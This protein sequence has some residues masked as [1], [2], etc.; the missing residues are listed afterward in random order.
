MNNILIVNN[1]TELDFHLEGVEVVAAK[2]YLYDSKYADMHNAR[3]FNLCRSYKYQST[4]YYVSLLAEARG[5]RVFPDVATIQDFG[6]QS[7]IRIISSDIDELIQHSLKKLKSKDFTLSIYFG[8]NVAKQYEKLS[9]EL[10]NLFQAPLVRARFIFNKKWILQH[11]A[12]IPL[13]EIPDHHKP[14]LVDFAKEYFARKTFSKKRNVKYRYDLAILVNPEED[15]PPSD[16]K[17]LQ[18]FIEAAKSCDIYTEFI[19]RD[20]FSR[21][22]EFDALFIR[23]TTSVNHHTYRF[24]RRAHQED[25]VVIDDPFSI[26]KCTNKVYLAELLTRAKIATPK[27]LIAHKD[28]IE[29]IE[30]EL[31]YPCVLKRP[32]SSF[33]QGVVKVDDR[34]SLDQALEKLLRTSDL[35]IAQEYTPTEFDWRIGIID[36]TPLYACKYYMASGHWQIYN[37]QKNKS[38]EFDG[39][40]QTLPI[41]QV[42]DII[43]ETA[44]KAANLIGDGLYGV[45]LKEIDS[46]AVVIEVNDN[47]SI[48]AGIE[49]AVLH[50]KL[51]NSIMQSFLNRLQKRFP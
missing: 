46:R 9:K 39:S 13:K 1:P 43:V 11:I 48:T 30:K 17:A 5:H 8:K 4:G 10:H 26:L 31:Q 50:E 37:W 27:T 41:Y 34:Q 40:T 45:D 47:P 12:P 23:E 35:I 51:Y 18:K 44:L 14:Y 7:I 42:P 33:S 21:I 25:L 3:I 24:A 36:Q 29:K 15:E 19:T 6:A 16:K 22:P 28:N 20:D 2:S 32:D 49:D 38:A